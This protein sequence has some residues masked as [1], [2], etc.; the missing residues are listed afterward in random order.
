MLLKLISFLAVGLLLRP[1]TAVCYNCQGI[2]LDGH[3]CNCQTG[4]CESDYCFTD[5]RPTEFSDKYRLVKGCIKKPTRLRVG[6]DY[7]RTPNSIQCICAGNYCNDAIYMKR[8]S[9]T[10]NITCRSCNERN[11]DCDQTCKGEWCYEDVKNGLTGCGF[12]PPSLPFLYKGYELLTSRSKV[13]ATLSR[14]NA[15]SQRH[16]ICNTHMCNDVFHNQA[17]FGISSTFRS[18]S[19]AV[20]YPELEPPK[21]YQ[22]VSCDVSTQENSVTSS[23]RQNKCYG[24][25][26]TFTTQRILLGSP[27]LGLNTPTIIH[28]KQGC[29]NV[30]DRR[31]VLI[32]CEHKWMEGEEEIQCSCMGDDCNA[33]IYTASHSLSIF[34]SLLLP[35]LLLP[36]VHNL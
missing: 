2:C 8:S 18:R 16:C 12:G 6:C 36:L 33:N 31:H 23:C 1:T 34:Q 22:C 24:H 13:C 32:G 4:F 3:E 7:D 26:C 28:E 19:V 17:L 21:V 10:R 20:Y 11:P 27:N 30:T 15:A 9:A 29:L 5:K 25:Y 14:G 35:L